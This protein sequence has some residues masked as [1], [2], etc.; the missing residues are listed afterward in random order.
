[1]E[2]AA[3]Q[4][5]A[6]GPHRHDHRRVLPR[7]RSRRAPVHRQHLPFHPRRY[8]GL[9][10]ARADAFGRGLSA[11]AGRGDGQASG[12]HHLHQEGLDHLDSGGVRARR[13]PHR[14]VTGHDLRAP[15][16]HRRAF[17][18]NRR[19]RHLPGGRS[20]RFHQ[21]SARPQRDR[22]VEHYETARRVQA[23]LQRY[24]ELKDIIAILG[25]DELSRKTSSPSRARARSSASSVSPSSWPKCSPASPAN[26]CRSRRP[27]AASR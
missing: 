20:A 26:T 4:P 8:R 14:P 17:A 1:M 22:G 13:R 12:A 21:P 19:A 2:R 9:G 15:R 16:C 23:T 5:T 11:D 24:K 10:A 6:R 25:M 18:P 27:S 3:G 7:R